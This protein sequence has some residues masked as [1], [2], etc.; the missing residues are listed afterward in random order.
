MCVRSRSKQRK[1]VVSALRH[2]DAQPGARAFL[3]GLKGYGGAGLTRRVQ[4]SSPF[5]L[6][7]NDYRVQVQVDAEMP[8][9][10]FTQND[11]KRICDEQI[12]GIQLEVARTILSL[13]HPCAKRLND[14]EAGFLD[15]FYTDYANFIIGASLSETERDALIRYRLTQGQFRTDLLASWGG[16]CSVTEC[17]VE[18]VLRA[19]H[20]K[21][22]RSSDNQERRNPE[23]GLLLIANLDALFDKFLITFDDDGRMLVSDRIEAGFYGQLGLSRPL[24]RSPTPA[25]QSFLE[26]HRREGITRGISCIPAPSIPEA[27]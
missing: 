14:D 21:P 12:P 26:H 17:S 10:P 3:W 11:V 27:T 24:R 23:N 22:W 15:N 13:A 20:I 9:H 4:I 5:E 16:Q 2:R 7:G 8:I 6:D 19:S 25:Q 18:A 1:A